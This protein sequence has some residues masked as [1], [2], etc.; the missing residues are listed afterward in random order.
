VII[1][2]RRYKTIVRNNNESYLKGNYIKTAN[3][4]SLLFSCIT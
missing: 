3:I 4:L 1:K 2:M